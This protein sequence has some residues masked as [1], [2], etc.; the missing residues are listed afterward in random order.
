MNLD[1]LYH[2]LQTYPLAVAPTLQGVR[3]QLALHHFETLASTSQTLWHMAKQGAEAGT[4]V[5]ARQQTAGRGQR[6]RRWVSS[7]GGVYLSMLLKP[8]WDSAIAPLLTFTSGW[9]IA[10]LLR[11]WGLP[12]KIKWPNDLV[13]QSTAHPTQLLKLGG[14]LTETRTE[15]GRIAAAVVG[16]GLNYANAVPTDGVDGMA[17]ATTVETILN[18]RLFTSNQEEAWSIELAAAT[19]LTGIWQGLCW[20]QQVGTSPFMQAY[21]QL[22]AHLGQTICVDGNLGQ[23][24]GVA[25][26]GQLWVEWLTSSVSDTGVSDTGPNIGRSQNRT[27]LSTEEVSLSY[28]I[29]GLNQAV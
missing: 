7:P 16:V 9:G 12:V 19:V 27:M 23:V 4:V 2:D 1:R 26:T 14:I 25:E 8:D 3:P 10:T 5:I 21:G 28:N 22:L 18:D 11:D 6:G 20:Q 13:V 24:I 15:A 29:A 17:A